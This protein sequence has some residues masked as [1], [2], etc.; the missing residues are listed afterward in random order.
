[1]A[2]N[3]YPFDWTRLFPRDPPGR[4]RCPRQRLTGRV[5]IFNLTIP[6]PLSQAVF[7]TQNAQLA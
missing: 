2:L 1:M 5:N 6:C 7:A 4:Y 3:R